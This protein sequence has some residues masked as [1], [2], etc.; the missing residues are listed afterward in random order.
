MLE[1]PDYSDEALANRF[2]SRY[3]DDLKFVNTWGRWLV[4]DGKW[5]FDDTLLVTD[6]ARGVARE[7]SGEILA[8]EGSQKLAAAVASAKTVSAI[9]R[10]A[11]ADRQH[12]SQTGDWDK[13]P[14]LLNTPTGTINLRTGQPDLTTGRD[15]MTKITAVGPGGSCPKWLEFLNRIFDGDQNLIAYSQGSSDIR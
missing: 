9:E 12:A 14:W 13:D 11:R 2:T 4:W 7:A 1:P 6:H 10:L 3:R 15:L 5:Q 8:R